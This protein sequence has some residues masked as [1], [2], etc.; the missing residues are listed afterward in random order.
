MV[1]KLVVGLG[2]PGNTYSGNRHNIGFMAI[3]HIADDYA[4]SKPSSK[5]GGMASEGSI[6]TQKIIAFKPMGYM[7]TSGG[8]VG[9]IARFYKIP[10]EHIIVIHDELDLPLG[11]LR[12]KLG[13][14]NGGHNGLKSIDAHIGKD[15]WRVRLGIGHPG[16]KDMV[17]SYVL[18]DFKK[19]EQ[20]A[21]ELMV[22]EVSRHLSLLLAGDE[23]GFMNKISLTIK[24]A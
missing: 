4:L 2:N 12:V 22:N 5:F 3:D 7:N 10:P 6:L 14:G 17:S 24:E 9:E 20:D 21:C 19:D 13:G 23:A 11:R 8:P 1:M 16:H 15:Y 18:S